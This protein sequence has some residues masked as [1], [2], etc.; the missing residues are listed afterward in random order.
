MAKTFNINQEVWANTAYTVAEP[1]TII[2]AQKIVKGNQGE[3]IAYYD[4]RG[5]KHPTDSYRNAY[6]TYSAQAENLYLTEDEAI[7]AAREE[8]ENLIIKYQN[9]ITDIESLINFCISF[10]DN[11]EQEAITAAEAMRDMLLHK[12]A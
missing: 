12:D 6:G 2:S 11:E 10:M 5:R 1:V 9:S 4:V 3:D 8:S 7:Q